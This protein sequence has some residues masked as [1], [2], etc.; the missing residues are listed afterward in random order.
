MTYYVA[1]FSEE[2]TGG[3]SVNFPELVGCYTEGKT[4]EEAF[5]NAENLLFTTIKTMTE[6]GENIEPPLSLEEVSAKYKEQIPTDR[7]YFFS[8][9][10]VQ[11]DAY[12]KNVIDCSKP[13]TFEEIYS[14][15]Y[16][17]G[18]TDGEKHLLLFFLFGFI[19]A[20]IC[21]NYHNWF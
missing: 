6:A 20:I 9:I 15:G 3:Y 19:M 8:F 12:Q 5:E 7:Y 14:C 18:V 17:E 16:D 11:E 13:P 2:K 4:V 21:M 10:P 1:V